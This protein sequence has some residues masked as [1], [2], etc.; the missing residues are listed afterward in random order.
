MKRAPGGTIVQVHDIQ[1]AGT[2]RLSGRLTLSCRLVALFATA[3]SAQPALAQRNAFTARPDGGGRQVDIRATG[4]IEY[5]DNVV[6]NDPRISGGGNSDDVI[7]SPSLDLRVVLPRATGSTYLAGSVGYRFYS[8][9][10]GLNRENISL[11]GGADQRIASCLVHGEVGYQRRIS[12]LSTLFALDAPDSFNN[13]EE[14]RRYSADVG[15]GR[16]YGLRPAL[17][18]SRTEVRNSQTVRKYADAN[19]DTL[20]AQLGLQSPSLGTISLFGRYANSVY[21]NR[22]RVPGVVGRDGIKSY[23]AGLQLERNISSRL[24]LR[25]SVNYTKVDPR[26]PGPSGFSGLGFDLS[27]LYKADLFTVQLSGSR[28]AQPSS[29]YFVSY[30]IMTVLSGTITHELSTRTQVSLN[31]S[32]TWRDYT[33]STLFPGAPISGSDNLLSLGANASYKATRRLRFDL[34]ADYDTRTSNTR[35]YKF[36]AKR[37]SFTTSLAL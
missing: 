36:H 1:Q 8:K 5:N 31:A 25:A 13:V 2:P 35:L 7:A 11:T 6:A 32:R 28:A 30:E 29:I 34:G 12:D 14:A 16:A 26:L 3:A 37:V 22:Q 17:A 19:T 9:Y 20:T 18:Y 21:I 24:D 23:A 10:A 27:A 15:C 4:S 33:S